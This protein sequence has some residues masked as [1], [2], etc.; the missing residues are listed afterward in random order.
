MARIKYDALIEPFLNEHYGYTFKP[1]RYGQVMM[2]GQPESRKR[3]AHQW[4]RQH[5]N[6]KAVTNWRNMSAETKANWNAFAAA[7][8][9]PTKANPDV[10]LNGYQLFI[11][12]N[13][14]CF[15][16]HGIESDFMEEPEINI[17][18]E[19]AITASIAW[20]DS[21]ID[22]TANYIRN[23]GILPVVGDFLLC[24]IIPYDEY[25]GAFF[26]FVDLS[27]EVEEIYLDGLFITVN[28]PDEMQSITC[29][30]YLSY[31]NKETINYF[32]TKSRYMGC[33]TKKKFTELTDTPSSYTGK[34]GWQV[35][36][37]ELETALEYIEAGGG[38]LTCET[39]AACPTIVA[40]QSTLQNIGE[41]VSLNL[42]TSIPTIKYGLLYN[43][44]FM[45]GAGNCTLAPAGWHCMTYAEY[46]TF[47]SFLGGATVAGAKLKETG[48][49]YWT[50]PNAGA[51]N[52]AKFNGRGAGNRS[53][54]GSFSAQKSSLIVWMNQISGSNGY[55]YVLSNVNTVLTNGALTRKS[56]VSM[57]LVKDST[58]LSDGETGTM[59][60]N[61]GKIYRTICIGTREF[62]A[63]NLAETKYPDGSALP[64]V[65][66][67]GAWAAL[68]TEAYCAYNN[69]WDNV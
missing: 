55:Y 37:N 46:N 58:S 24:R 68:S 61:D 69:D 34:G 51:T 57:R 43:H 26:N 6:Q 11:K 39:L 50:S 9:Q 19:G 60:G 30:V 38:G 36:V 31:K 28:V 5:N 8:P 21:A 64:L 53:A 62:M 2:K 20:T 23:F 17:I 59:T 48:T 41:I 22:A 29:S 65:E 35:A 66:D 49:T 42:D 10:Y 40:I 54:G 1:G 56:G 45:D 4:E 18:D 13:S 67:A 15:L 14:Y 27:L 47:K 3:N 44:F 7:Y 52:L 33:F 12:R 32:G 63:D 25:S 16:N